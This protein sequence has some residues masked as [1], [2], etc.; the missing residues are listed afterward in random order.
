MADNRDS[1]SSVYFLLS[2]LTK[3]KPSLA[4]DV[5]LDVT[6]QFRQYDVNYDTSYKSLLEDVIIEMIMSGRS[7]QAEILRS[8]CEFVSSQISDSV[9]FLL[10][11]CTRNIRKKE[12]CLPESIFGMDKVSFFAVDAPQHRQFIPKIFREPPGI[13][14]RDERFANGPYVSRLSSSKDRID[15]LADAARF[16]MEQQSLWHEKRLRL[17][18]PRNVI[19]ISPADEVSSRLLSFVKEEFSISQFSHDS[20]PLP[21]VRDVGGFLPEV[22]PRDNELLQFIL[23]RCVSDPDI[24]DL[25]AGTTMEA[26]ARSPLA[27]TMLQENDVFEEETRRAHTERSRC[28]RRRRAVVNVQLMSKEF[29]AMSPN[30][31]VSD[32]IRRSA[33]CGAVYRDLVTFAEAYNGATERRTLRAVADFAFTFARA[34]FHTLL[35]VGSD[36]DVPASQHPRAVVH[37]AE[38][39]IADGCNIAN[40]LLRVEETDGSSVSI[41]NTLLSRSLLHPSNETIA[42]LF[43]TAVTPYFDNICDWV[44][45]GSSRRDLGGEFFGTVLGLSPSASEHLVRIDG[46]FDE[47]ISNC[48]LFPD[49]FTKEESLF[50][51]RAGRTRSLLQFLGLHDGIL[52]TR[53]PD[54]SF[55]DVK[56]SFDEVKGIFCELADKVENPVQSFEDLS[57]CRIEAIAESKD[58][59]PKQRD[60]ESS[61]K[62][63]AWDLCSHR[64]GDS[65]IDDLSLSP[66]CVRCVAFRVPDIDE[67]TACSSK[68]DDS[69]RLFLFKTDDSQTDEI[70]KLETVMPAIRQKARFPVGTMFASQFLAPL[71]RIDAVVQR[72][73]LQYFIEALGLYDH[74]YNLRAHVLLGAGDF[75][76]ELIDQLEAAALMSDASELFDRRRTNASGTSYSSVGAG[77]RNRRDRTYLNQCLKTALNLCGEEGNVLADLLYLESDGNVIEHRDRDRRLSLEQSSL[78]E[79]TMEIRYDTGYPL[80]FVITQEAMDLYSKIFGLFLRIWRARKSLR[81]MF[82]ASRRKRAIG[83]SKVGAVMKDARLAG[84]VWQFCWHAEHFVSIFGG[85]V[86]EQVLGSCWDE[87]EQRWHS[88]KSVWDLRDA[89]LQFLEGCVRRCLLSDKHKA[90]LK[91]MTGGFE[92]VVNVN[93]EISKLSVHDVIGWTADVRSVI[94]LL[95][96]ATASLKRRCT[97]L[98]DV[99]ERLMEGG[100]LPHLEYLLTRLNFNHY[101]EPAEATT[102]AAPQ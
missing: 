7:H 10:L 3:G 78:W 61:S 51:L 100:T 43:Y 96:S 29:P 99:L 24:D 67:G 89:H 16:N 13:D 102:S 80:N 42:L 55:G 85:F 45:E 27:L 46:T 69:S 32:L 41:I 87:F 97:F 81:S 59:T 2:S 75:A 33:V 11:M 56:L 71:R 5:L 74:L 31:D 90:V 34:Y 88:A 21:G 72:E 92:I 62:L 22:S 76:N 1:L 58:S 93:S 49:I 28:V 94:E 30:D 68:D 64:A 37:A 86:M 36:S 25:T 39:F 20:L 98:T 84:R 35:K 63:D 15:C 18:S 8:L 44:F 79:S 14:D 38:A 9:L 73:V 91:V 12:H 17:A 50:L 65:I 82:V 83:Q 66:T 77:E 53:P 70:M 4:Y 60:K 101:F 26:T 40:A 6:G 57:D 95:A 47:P 19:T 52:A 48:A 54:V 23:S